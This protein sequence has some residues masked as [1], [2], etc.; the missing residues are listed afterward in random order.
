MRVRADP[1]VAVRTGAGE[2][3]L[4]PVVAVE[5][6]A[7]DVGV[8]AD[9][10]ARHVPV[11]ARGRALDAEQVALRVR[12]VVGVAAAERGVGVVQPRA[13]VVAR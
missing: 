11:P 4:Q 9:V 6:R 13:L 1:V 5:V 3:L 7:G 12:L 8:A 10:Q 2:A